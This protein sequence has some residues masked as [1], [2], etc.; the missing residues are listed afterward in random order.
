MSDFEYSWW[1]FLNRQIV[2]LCEKCRECTLY[3][4]N[5]TPAK[6]FHTAQAFPT[7]SGPNQ[8]LQFYFAGPILDIQNTKVFL[9]VAVD[10]FSK[11][12]S[13]FITKTTGAKKVLKILDSHTRIHGIPR[14]IKSHYGSGFKN[15][16]VSIFCAIRGI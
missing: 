8:E 14:Y 4:N 11:F 2:D 3:G 7:L 9:L 5:F 12:P 6:T 10:L 1:P 15:D 16:L 13:V